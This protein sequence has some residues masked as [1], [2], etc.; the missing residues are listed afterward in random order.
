MNFDFYEPKNNA[1]HAYNSIRLAVK[2]SQSQYVKDLFRK[3]MKYICLF[4]S[5]T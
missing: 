1:R 4:V 3:I 5:I 2:S